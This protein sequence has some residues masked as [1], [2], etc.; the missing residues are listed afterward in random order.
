VNENLLRVKKNSPEKGFDKVPNHIIQ[1]L[2]DL[3]DISYRVFMFL[4]SQ[5]KEYHPSYVNIA[6]RLHKSTSAIAR[7]VKELKNKGYLE[8]S[9][10]SKSH[11]WI[12]KEQ[13]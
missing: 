10:V 2:S 12:L 9:P 3:T 8:I 11:F 13:P 7:A 5:G 6:K 4:H 1:G